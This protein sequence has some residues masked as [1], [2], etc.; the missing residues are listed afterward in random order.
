MITGIRITYIKPR[1][2]K[3]G[4]GMNISKAINLE[5]GVGLYDG[6]GNL[7]FETNMLYELMKFGILAQ[8][9]FLETLQDSLQL[10]EGENAAFNLIA[11]KLYH[12]ESSGK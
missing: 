2:E 5:L 4:V 9:E 7:F 12:Q 6:A 11:E 10:S 8:I 3:G 1:P